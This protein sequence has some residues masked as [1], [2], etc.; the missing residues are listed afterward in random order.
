MKQSEKETTKWGGGFTEVYEIIKDIE[1]G[2]QQHTPDRGM[3]HCQM[4]V[5]GGRFC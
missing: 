3:G 4:K 5:V 2:D 1:R